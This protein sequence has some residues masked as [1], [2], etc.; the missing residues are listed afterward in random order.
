MGGPNAGCKR[1]EIADMGLGGLFLV[2]ATI[3][4]YQLADRDNRR[5]WLWAGI[6]A[7]AAMFLAQLGRLGG[8]GVYLAFVGTIAALIYTKPIRRN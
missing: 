6:N 4:I 1:F 5:G 7:V 8:L 2:F 3:V